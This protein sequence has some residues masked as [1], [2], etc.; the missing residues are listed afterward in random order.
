MAKNRDDKSTAG[1]SANRDPISGAPGAHPVGVGAGSAGAGAAGAAIGGIVGGPIGAVVGA[2]IGAVAGG[3]G[4]KAAAETVN[5]TVEDAFWRDN[6]QTR[7]Y[8]KK[9][10]SYDT[11][12]PAYKYG[13]ESRMMHNG[14][15]WTDVE[16]DLERNWMSARGQSNLGWNDARPAARDAWDRL[17]KNDLGG[18]SKKVH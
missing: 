10:A 8:A 14:K 15:K 16:S 6:Y 18:D 11:Y 17:D 3:L 9:E 13:W 5:P 1:G 2:A 7:S 12:Q 4:G